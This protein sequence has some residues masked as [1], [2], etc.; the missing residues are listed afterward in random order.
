[1]QGQKEQYIQILEREANNKI[2]WNNL[3]ELYFRESDFFEAKKC[4]ENAIDIDGNYA[5][6]LYNLSLIY[7]YQGFLNFD[8][9]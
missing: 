3:G 8:Y 6:A 1:M 7:L 9:L 2:A 5:N 4:F